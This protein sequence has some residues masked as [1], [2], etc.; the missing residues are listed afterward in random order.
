MLI[1][2]SNLIGL[3]VGALDSQKK[4]GTVKKIIIDPDNGG[5]LGFEIKA[6][7]FF[8]KNKIL[9]IVDVSEFD[10]HGLV[11]RSE[12]NLVDSTEIIRV[13]KVL[14]RKIKVL[15]TKAITESK[16][17]LGKI[18]DLLIDID[19]SMIVKYYIKGLWQD[20]I[21]PANKVIKITAGAVI[22]AEDAIEEPIVAEAEG[23]AAQ[24]SQAQIG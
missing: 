11:T 20:R 6:R 3:P 8:N 4:I 2:T 17:Y 15:G 12:E 22:F 19:S 23:A 9:S 10:R 14:K 16:Q 24:Q 7:G 21:L 1:Q 5:F 18:N 13:D